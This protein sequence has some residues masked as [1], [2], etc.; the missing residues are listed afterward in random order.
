MMRLRRL[1]G[2]LLPAVAVIRN[3]EDASRTIR[4]APEHLVV[5]QKLTMQDALDR[6]TSHLLSPRQEMAF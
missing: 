5:P 4:Q 3:G 1:Q 2:R 6:N